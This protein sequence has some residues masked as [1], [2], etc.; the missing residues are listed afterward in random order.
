M[1]ADGLVTEAKA[2]IVWGE[3]PTSVRAFLITNGISA[4]DADSTVQ[5][6]VTARAKEIRIRGIIG[7][8]TGAIVIAACTTYILYSL[9]HPSKVA[10]TTRQQRLMFIA[11]FIGLYGIW[12]LMNG[13][14]DLLHPKSNTQPMS[15]VSEI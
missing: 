9:K 7:A 6:L 10:I 8:C 3:D 1:S 2:R 15:D 13:L 5:D 11:G 12:K 4:A 14:G